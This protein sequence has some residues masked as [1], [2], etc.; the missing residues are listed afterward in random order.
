MLNLIFASALLSQNIN[1]VSFKPLENDLDARVNYPKLDQ[2]GDVAAIIKVVTTTTN[3]FFDVGS[4]G[5]VT[6]VQKPG[7]VWVYVPRGVRRISISHAQLGVLRD[8]LLG[9]PIKAASVYEMVLVTSEIEVKIKKQQEKLQYIVIDSEPPGASV[10]IDDNLVGKTPF[11]RMFLEGEYN[12]RLE[13][14]KYY[15]SAGKINLKDKKF[16]ENVL[17]KPNYGR[18]YVNSF[19]EKGLTIYLNDENTGLLTPAMLE[20]VKS[21]E[22]EV[23]LEG[24]WYKSSKEKINVYDNQ[25]SDLNFELQPMFGTLK[26]NTLTDSAKVTIDGELEESASFEKRLLKGLY[27]VKVE[28]DKFYSEEKIVKIEIGDAESLIFDL[29]PI[30]G[31][32]NISSTP[33]KAKVFLNEELLGSTPDLFNNIQIGEYSLRLRKEGFIDYQK[34]ILI[35][36]NETLE[37]KAEL[38]ETMFGTLNVISEPSGASIFLNKKNVGS[39]PLRIENLDP[40]TYQLKIEAPNH[41]TLNQEVE[42][43]IGK[44]VEINQPLEE[45]KIKYDFWYF[46]SGAPITF[47]GLRGERGKDKMSITP[48]NLFVERTFF[49]QKIALRI[50]AQY[51]QYNYYPY[52][53][54]PNYLPLLDKYISN[55]NRNDFTTSSVDNQTNIQNRVKSSL[56]SYGIDLKYNFLGDEINTFLALSY[57]NRIINIH[58]KMDIIKPNNNQ[59]NFSKIDASESHTFNANL[60]G[61]RAGQMIQLEKHLTL[62]YEGGYMYN[63]IRKK[64]QYEFA[65][66]LGLKL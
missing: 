31:N 20:K 12:Y 36:E 53:E 60:V 25:Q 19:P 52:E 48:F 61:L 33:H 34:T 11:N 30:E 13:L 59:T 15:S 56:L 58:D 10:F 38:Y 45:I 49:K 29:K 8:Y 35:K 3:L 42:L 40:G 55:D 41:K 26:I 6:T 63:D 17:L 32:L 50:N 65:I 51:G 1:V 47:T 7:E 27:N 39:T 44:E 21:G 24:N 23:K 9:I 18:I 2:N 66:L 14:N 43:G 57:S 5:V 37:V 54:E 46:Y 64:F 62:S 4:L 28:A 16:E 22:H